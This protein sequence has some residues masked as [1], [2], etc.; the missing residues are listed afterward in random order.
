V[1][2]ILGNF[3]NPGSHFFFAAQFVQVGVSSVSF[4][5]YLSTPTLGSLKRRFIGRYIGQ[6]NRFIQYLEFQMLNC[7]RYSVAVNENKGVTN[8]VQFDW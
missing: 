4:S 5:F 6:A 8:T 2:F 7:S 3:Q 1:Y